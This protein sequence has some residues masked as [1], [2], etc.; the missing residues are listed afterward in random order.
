MVDT[1]LWQE[2][3]VAIQTNKKEEKKIKHS[4]ERW[5][6]TEIIVHFTN[7]HNAALLLLLLVVVVV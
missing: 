4:L 6:P 3:S 2:I 1:A 5:N 7:Q